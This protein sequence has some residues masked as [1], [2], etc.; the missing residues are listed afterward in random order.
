V[1]RYPDRLRYLTH[2]NHENR[3]MSASRNLGIANANGKYIAFLD[4]DDV[5]L[6][7][8][9][10]QQVALLD[11]QPYA[12]MVY[13]ATLLWY[14]WTGQATD[15][16]RDRVLPLGV[17]S[18][19]LLEPPALLMLFLQRKALP[20][21]TCN[22]LVR[23]EVVE[24]VGGFEELFRGLYED[25]AFFAKICLNRP[26][27]ATA[28][29]SAKYRQHPD[30]SVALA[31]SKGEFHPIRPSIARLT[32]LKWLEN[33]LDGQG[34]RGSLVWRDLQAELWPYRHPRLYRTGELVKSAVRRSLPGFMRRRL[35]KLFFKA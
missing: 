27:F 3:G 17:K 35:R 14:G 29:C 7:H 32:F 5:W 6:P 12:A 28:D 13:G 31:I 23:R 2:P 26:V 24:V 22:I 4:A 25:Q 20:P 16:A 1:A 18:D 9:L 34:A 8:K 19:T 11:A 30:S 21:G 15:I 33:Y 10:E